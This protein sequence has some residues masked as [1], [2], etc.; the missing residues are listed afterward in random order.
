MRRNSRKLKNH[1]KS[2]SDKV[3]IYSCIVVA[4]LAVVLIGLLLYSKSLSEDVKEG[5]TKLEQMANFSK[6]NENE[7]TQ[8]ASTEIGKTV[9]ES[10]QETNTTNNTI[11]NNAQ[12]DNIIKNT[13]TSV[14]NTT[15]SNKTNTNT[16][17]ASTT[18][19]VNAKKEET[20]KELS[21]AKPVDGEIMKEFAK[22]N[23]VY[24]NTL[25]EWVTHLGI[26]IKAEK[27]T[28]VKSAE[29][30]K[31]KSIKNDPRYGLTVTI[32]HENGYK[33]IY[34]N[35]LSAEFVAEQQKVEKGQ[36]IGTVGESSSFEIADEPH[37]HFEMYKD[38]E[39]V[40]P[41]IYLQ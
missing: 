16:N 7:N 34:S 40:N 24:S 36:T 21:F 25:E 37:L 13:N 26:D 15:K 8:S 17:K 20:K 3:I 2:R 18:T 12:T 27:T 38:G 30:G 31:V 39:I 14:N 41:T 29:A 33:T 22:E 19:N 1:S 23:L 28:V 6:S 35:L 9:E 32:A 11:A 5:T 4:V 10:K